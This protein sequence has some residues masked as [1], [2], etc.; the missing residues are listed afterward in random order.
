MPQFATDECFMQGRPL[1]ASVLDDLTE[2]SP[3]EPSEVLQERFAREQYL[4]LRDV[5]T[6]AEVDEVRSEV[7][8]QLYSVGEVESPGADGIYTGD[9]RRAEL[10]G[11]LGEFWKDISQGAA[12]RRLSHGD[13]ITEIMSKVLGEPAVA[14]DYLFLRPA[15]PG[16]STHLHYDH[17]FFARGSDR[18]VTVWTAYGDIPVKEG[19]LLVVDGSHTF[20][21]LVEASQGVDYE[22]SNTPLVQL[23]DDPTELARSR[24]VKLKTADFR[25][26]DVIL[27]S[28]TLL[29]GSLDNRSEQGRIRLSSDVRWQPA[30]DP[31]DPRYVGEDPP[32]TTG[33]GYGELNGAKPLTIDWHQR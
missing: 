9:S 14:H 28:M 21:D 22:S 5:F 4:F 33:A 17:P 24:G 10:A 25:A 23:L 29:H 7:F 16:R 3:D 11:D 6:G 15:I 31:V 20:D 12:L 26:G 27:F 32:G 19:P 8:T 30:C 1:D 18:I 2:S 13:R